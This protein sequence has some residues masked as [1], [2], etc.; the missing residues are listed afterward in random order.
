MGTLVRKLSQIGN[1][2]GIILPQTVLEMLNWDLDAEIE[3]KI[4]GKK[5]IVSP[6]RRRYA[7]EEEAKAVADRVFTKHRQ[8]MAKLSK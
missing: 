7:T 6:C 2:K 5:L 1:S 8:L 4:E 3:L